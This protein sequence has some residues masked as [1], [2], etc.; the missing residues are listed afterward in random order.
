MAEHRQMFSRVFAP[1]GTKN[2]VNT[3]GGEDFDPELAVEVRR[4]SLRSRGCS[5]GPAGNTAI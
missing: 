3:D 4:G 5:S 2:T 1:L